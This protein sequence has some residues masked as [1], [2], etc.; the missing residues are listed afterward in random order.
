MSKTQQSYA[1][2]YS[3]S[4]FWAKI[5]QCA[6]AVDRQ[7]R[8]AALTLH[9]TF[10]DPDAPLWVKAACAAA[11]GYLILPLDAIPDA[12]MPFGYL[13]DVAVMAAAL[14]G[15]AAHV[16]PSAKATA[17]AKVRQWVGAD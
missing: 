1:Q 15:I 14:A 10:Q 8:E 6:H 5:R 17:A 3:E 16:R 12:L 9:Y 2:H 7:T 4:G 13:D 11:L